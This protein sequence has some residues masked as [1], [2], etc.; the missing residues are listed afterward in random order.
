MFGGYTL[1]NLFDPEIEFPFSISAGIP[2]DLKSVCWAFGSPRKHLFSFL[3]SRIIPNLCGKESNNYI[4]NSALLESSSSAVDEQAALEKMGVA[5]VAALQGARNF[6]YLGNLCVDDLFSGVQFVIDVE[7]VNYIKEVIESFNP[8]PDVVSMDRIYEILR[9]VSLGKEQFLSHPD[10]V[11]KFR[12]I[13][14]SSDLLRR[15]KLRQWLTHK[16]ILKDR[17]REECINRIKNQPEFHLPADK[18]KALDKI[19]K[20]AEASLVK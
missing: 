10:T 18:E 16:K 6:S 3:N 4:C 14:P 19:Y 9:D 11:R 17:A 12:N 7:I 5:M 8:H 13:L 2:T 15:E 1:I 20:R